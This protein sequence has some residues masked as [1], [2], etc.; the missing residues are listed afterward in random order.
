MRWVFRFRI[1]PTDQ[2]EDRMLGM[3]ETCRRLWN[4][5]L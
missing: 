4:D 1:Y 3:V 2:Q 5:A